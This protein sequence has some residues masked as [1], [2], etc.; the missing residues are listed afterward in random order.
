MATLGY[1]FKGLGKGT[2][3]VGLQYFN[4][5]RFEGFDDIGLATGEFNAN[6]YALVIG[7]AIRNKVFSYGANLKMLG[8]VLEGY[9]AHALVV[10]FGVNF[11]HPE[12]DL[13]LAMNARNIGFIL[14]AYTEGVSLQLPADFRIGGS[15]KPEYAPFRF[16]LT[17]RNLQRGEVDFYIPD[18]FGNS[19]ELPI[20][21]RIFRR[22]VFG[23]ELLPSENFNL[24]LGYNHLIRKEFET[25][26]GA[27]AG[28]FSGGFAFKVKKFELSY[29]RMFYNV[30][31]G[32]NIFGITTLI[33]DKRTF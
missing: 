32:S 29:S 25:E 22:M 30:P 28:G 33:K 23:V 13:V 31:G 12:H 4:Y 18:P 9:Q 14:G 7:Y 6:E 10:D 21:D 5:G 26:S 17:L 2:M 19:G 1:N 3:G 24:R 20:A 27:G 16:H 11:L 8:S 15:F